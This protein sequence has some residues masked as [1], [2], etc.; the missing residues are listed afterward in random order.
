[1]QWIHEQQNHLWFMAENLNQY[2]NAHLSMWQKNITINLFI[3]NNYK[4]KG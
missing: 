3:F 1:M 4:Y 2:E